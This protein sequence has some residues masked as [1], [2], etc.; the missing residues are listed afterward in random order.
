MF[1]LDIRISEPWT[2]DLGLTYCRTSET[3]VLWTFGRRLHY[4][5]FIKYHLYNKSFMPS[6][7]LSEI[8]ILHFTVKQPINQDNHIQKT[9][10]FSSG[11][12]TWR[13]Y[14]ANKAI[15]QYKVASN[16]LNYISY[17][18]TRSV[19]DVHRANSHFVTWGGGG[20]G[21]RSN[22]LHIL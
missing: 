4:W 3:S 18:C 7:H 9:P 11:Y 5:H 8:K 21:H 12:K 16:S 2:M 17:K 19:T 13:L 22:L 10:Y 1:G 20:R 14:H 6:P 15:Y